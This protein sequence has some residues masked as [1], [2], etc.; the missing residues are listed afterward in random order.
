MSGAA[1]PLQ[2]AVV[3]AI[4]SAV[5]PVPVYDVPQ[6]PLAYPFVLVGDDASKDWS[7]S[8]SNGED[9]TISIQVWSQSPDREEMK[10][11]QKQVYDAL[12]DQNLTVSGF[13]VAALIFVSAESTFDEEKAALHGTSKFR[14]LLSA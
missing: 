1:W 5:A 11:L 8:E 12:H 13:E 6:D 7:T 2:E 3:T 9:V 14:C 10:T 4:T